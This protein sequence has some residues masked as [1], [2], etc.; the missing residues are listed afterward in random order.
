MPAYDAVPRLPKLA[1]GK[2]LEV[3]PFRWWGA[4]GIPQSG[5]TY[6]RHAELDSAGLRSPWFNRQNVWTSAGLTSDW[7]AEL[8]VNQQRL[9]TLLLAEGPAPP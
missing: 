2:D 1:G 4:A 7:A 8:V 5:C 9:K 3:L 6:V